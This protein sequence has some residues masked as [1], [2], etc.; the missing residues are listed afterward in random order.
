MLLH[1]GIGCI[2]SRSFKNT[3]PRYLKAEDRACSSCFVF[4]NLPNKYLAQRLLRLSMEDPTPP[5]R[6]PA[7]SQD[8]RLLEGHTYMTL[9]KMVGP[10]ADGQEIR[11]HHFETRGTHR[12][13]RSIESFQGFGT[14]RFLDLATIRSCTTDFRGHPVF[15]GAGCGALATRCVGFSRRMRRSRRRSR[16]WP[17][18][19]SKAL[20]SSASPRTGLIL[21]IPSLKNKPGCI[22]K[23]HPVMVVVGKHYA[24]LLIVVEW[25]IPT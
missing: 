2:S 12:W 9:K 5:K 1:P 17:C 13:Y 24:F 22:G 4:V 10:S 15:P 6:H 8:Q 21:G 14:V 23:K 11:S 16:S 3:H 25:E 18:H 20:R 19:G 7:R